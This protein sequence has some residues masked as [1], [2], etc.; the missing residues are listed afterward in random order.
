MRLLQYSEES[1][2]IFTA[3]EVITI[4]MR[5]SVTAVDRKHAQAHQPYRIQ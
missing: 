5:S 3:A 2:R 1:K 4:T